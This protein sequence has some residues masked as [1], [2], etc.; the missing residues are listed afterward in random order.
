MI[1]L[2]KKIDDRIMALKQKN[3]ILSLFFDEIVNYNPIIIGGFIRNVI[4]EEKSRD[5]D[6]ILNCDDSGKINK[7]IDKYNLNYKKN[8][9]DGYK[10]NF[11]DIYIDIWCIK[12]H[13]LFKKGIYEISVNNL[14]KTTFINYDSL[15]YEIN[16]K[17]LDIDNYLKCL[18]S[19]TIDFVGNEDAIK[20]NPNIYLSIVKIFNVCY[21]K[22]MNISER[23]NNY[24]LSLHDN[25]IETTIIKLKKE[26]KKHYNCDISN[27][28]EKY[29]TNYFYQSNQ[30]ILVKK[31]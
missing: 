12:N 15:I 30:K 16:T 31:Y 21:E 11:N 1:C 20:N 8:Q 14:K 27:E 19:S 18:Y 29:I 28:L 13:N 6:I 10:I 24:I 9:F 3:N 4:N 17:K 7:I 25:D 2:N 26:Y 23:V 22:N 5:I